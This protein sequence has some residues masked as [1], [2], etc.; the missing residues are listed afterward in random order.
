MKNMVAMIFCVLMIS[1]CIAEAS[2][3]VESTLTGCVED[4][5]FYSISLDKDSAKAY[6]VPFTHPVDLKPYEGKP[7]RVSGW[8]SPGSKF[9]MHDKTAIQV[10]GDACDA[11]SRKAIRR[12]H[13]VN[14]RVEADKAARKENF[15]KALTL[16]DKAFE[17]YPGD[18]DNYSDRAEIYCMKN[19]FGAVARD[20]SAIKTGACSN[21]AKANY[22]LL[23]DVAK[24][25]ERKGKRKEA[26]D[27]YRLAYD[28]CVGRGEPNCKQPISQHIRRLD[29]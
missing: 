15:D 9:T 5:V 6:K 20:M 27:A 29:Q 8:L 23:E 4:G 12:Q 17:I 2:V 24:C 26:L 18:C 25:L 7:V 13:A 16:M 22:L 3:P 11:I 1:P 21:A 28:G 10:T 14:Y 19:D